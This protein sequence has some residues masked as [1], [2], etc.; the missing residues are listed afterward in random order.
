MKEG[1]S[2]P[3]AFALPVAIQQAG[4]AKMPMESRLLQNNGPTSKK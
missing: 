2:L 1:D 3:E 4:T